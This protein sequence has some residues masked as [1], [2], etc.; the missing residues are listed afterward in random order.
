MERLILCGGGHVSLELAHIASRLDFELHVLDDRLEFAGPARFPMASTHC[1]PFVPELEQLGSGPTDYFAVLTR[2]HVWDAQCAA[3][4]LRGEFAY[5]G[6]I[7][8]RKK[9]AA[10]RQAL[11]AEGIPPRLLERLH[12]PIGL[13]LGGQ[14]PAEIAV[15]IAAQLIQ[16]R[17]AH[18][19]AARA[20]PKG[21][22]MLA[23]IVEKHGSAPR[24]VGTAMLV[25]PDGTCTGTIGGGALEFQV[26]RLALDLMDFNAA[27][28]RR[29][30]DL[31][32]DL[33]MVCGGTVVI[34]FR[35]QTS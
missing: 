8:S 12:A 3:H 16:V 6:M 28:T 21:E 20:I 24:G 5:L 14:S 15:S 26:R 2:G 27:P 25:A 18:G 30:F 35:R 22:G 19:G 9:V 7:G 17:A 31:G 33:G 10:V 13:P 29:T 32:G 34:E 11:L 1:G 4:I 23:T